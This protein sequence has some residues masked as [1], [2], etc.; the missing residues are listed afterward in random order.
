MQPNNL[1]NI[2]KYTERQ[3]STWFLFILLT[4][5]SNGIWFFATSSKDSNI[6]TI[7]TLRESAKVWH[8]AYVE[9]NNELVECRADNKQL[10]KEL[11][12]KTS[13]ETKLLIDNTKLTN[14]NTTLIKREINK[15]KMN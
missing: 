12:E 5:L 2:P 10:E 9:K 11:K 8:D 7:K 13:N 4:L 3:R 15:L 6:E 1:P 14:Q